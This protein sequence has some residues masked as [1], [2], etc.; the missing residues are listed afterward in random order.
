MDGRIFEGLH[1]LI[2]A[3]IENVSAS[4]DFVN[5]TKEMNTAEAQKQLN[6]IIGVRGS[7]VVNDKGEYED[8][9]AIGKHVKRG[10]SV[11]KIKGYGDKL[12]TIQKCKKVFL[13][14]DSK[15]KMV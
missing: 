11:I 8:K 15:N 12:E 7:I 1:G 10:D 5:A 3:Q 14:I 4:K 6:G 13:Y 9:S 2:P